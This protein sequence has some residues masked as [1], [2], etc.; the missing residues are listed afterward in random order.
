MVNMVVVCGSTGD[1]FDRLQLRLLEICTSSF[2][3]VQLAGSVS[4][5][6]GLSVASRYVPNSMEQVLI[7]FKQSTSAMMSSSAVA[8]AEV[9]KGE[10]LVFMVVACHTL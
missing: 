7:S 10:L 8:H 3:V 2:L 5:G 6:D 9:P 1:C 4:T